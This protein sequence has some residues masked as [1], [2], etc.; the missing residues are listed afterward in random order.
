MTDPES[1]ERRKAELEVHFDKQRLDWETDSNLDF[2]G[3]LPLNIKT[4]HNSE[5][6]VQ[7]NVA[8]LPPVD[9]FNSYEKAIPGT[10]EYIMKAADEQRR[11]RLAIESQQVARSERRRD[12]GQ[13]ISGLLAFVGLG[14]AIALGLFG[15]PWVAA[16]LATIAVGGPLAAQTLAGA[17]ARQQE[18]DKQRSPMTVPAPTQSSAKNPD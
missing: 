2:S 12:I 6:N 1:G 16:I 14:G 7:Y 8:L 10:A 11:H 9:D 17:L 13:Y 4:G 18:A 3:A 15:N 5:V